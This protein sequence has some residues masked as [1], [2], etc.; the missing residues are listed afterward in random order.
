MERILIES[1][2]RVVLLAVGTAAVLRML[3]VTTAA[4]RHAAWTVV[5]LAMLTMPVWTVWGPKAPLPVLPSRAVNMAP[6]TAQIATDSVTA[7]A[8]TPLAVG[9]R[10]SIH[11]PLDAQRPVRLSWRAI[12]LLTYGAGVLLLLGR[13][14]IGT[15][16]AQRIIRRAD[17]RDG[18]L[19]SPRCSAPV[20]V[21]WIRSV[22]LL[23]EDW[24]TWSPAKLDAVLVHERE[25]A[26]RRDPLIQWFALLN[27][28]IFWFHPMAWWLERRL[29]SLAEDACDA[30][31]LSRGHLPAEYCEYLLSM[32]RAVTG[33]GARVEIV[34]AAMPGAFLS[35][36]IRRILKAVPE[37]QITRRR[38]AWALMACA[39][40]SVA[41]T[42][43]TLVP[44]RTRQGAAGQS[45]QGQ[46][47]PEYWFEDDEW[48]LEAAP[49]MSV[50]E[51]AT[52][53]ALR[54]VAARRAFITDFWERHDP[55]RGTSANE[56]RSE[57]ERRIRY[58]KEHYADPESAAT[59]GYQTDRG[60]WYVKS[61]PP[62]AVRVFGSRNVDRYGV[63]PRIEEWD[64]HALD[65]LGP[66][67]RIRF[68]VGSYFGCTYR[69]GKYRILSPGPVARFEGVTSGGSGQRP[70]AQTYPG[71]F[72]YLSFPIDEQAVAVHWG[73]RTGADG[74]IILHE[75][76]GPIDYVQGQFLD[77]FDDPNRPTTAA[78]KTL[79]SHFEGLQLFEPNA[80]AC[81]EQ[82]PPATYTLRIDTRLMNGAKRTDSV[83]FALE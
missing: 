1:A 43:A 56:F 82:L 67:V 35:Q 11:S 48:H 13:L 10:G 25:H 30:A 41:V 14:L 47:L 81:T 66:N 33:A 77:P 59:F 52:Y 26:R 44:A 46:A 4:A 38:L 80:I 17:V 70:F 22:V 55:T 40:L 7:P 6:P 37:S 49:L 36:R 62:D 83:T 32:A 5:L 19:T 2:F 31:V 50:A 21:G 9:S 23:P 29:A 53:R 68:D 51:M 15:V 16:R 8:A 3:R 76:T 34:G 58:A 42:T 57:F 61:G 24:K 79:M 69:G 54:T 73:M 72:V 75:E 20:T 65:D 64:Y 39:G 63:S 78:V 28:A 12:A 45:S 18:Q 60:R 71:H 74:R 27:R